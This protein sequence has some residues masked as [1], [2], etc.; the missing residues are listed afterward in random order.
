[1]RTLS[2]LLAGLCCLLLLSGCR[3]HIS[4]KDSKLTA[5][6]PKIGSADAALLITDTATVLIDTGEENDS[7][8]IL[9]LLEE[10]GRSTID[11]MLISHYDKDHV[12]GAAA[13]M[14][15]CAVKRVI[16]S[17]SPKDSPEME[18]YQ[19]ALKASKLTE[20]IPTAPLTI[21]LGKLYL[22]VYPPQ[23]AS[24]SQDQS[25]NSSTV[26]SISY[27]STNFLFTGDAMA[28][29]TAELAPGLA[30]N[31][32]DLIKIPHHGRDVDTASQLLPAIKSGGAA[33]ITS[34]KKEPENPE[35][36]TYLER[37][38]LHVYLTRNGA[39]TV[40]SDGTSLKISQ[41]D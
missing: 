24:Y 21:S 2:K 23:Q 25:N 32:Y 1:M 30:E 38:G 34:S 11:L 26:I 35:L 14:D 22:V 8:E 41:E 6:F 17:T 39:L 20:E 19:A 36:L 16:G 15:A 31:T 27:G 28:A 3:S 4:S 9:E 18:S 7:D 10:Y 40:T 13:I 33:V 37:S 12:G 5:V 29:R